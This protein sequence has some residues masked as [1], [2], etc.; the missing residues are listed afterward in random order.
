MTVTQSEKELR[1]KAEELSKKYLIIDTHIDVPYRL[2]IDFEDVS[3]KTQRG[4]FDFV[5]AKTGGL[6]AVFMAI[7][8]PAEFEEKG[9]GK[10]F[11]EELIE[12]IRELTSKNPDKF[13]LAASAEEI[14]RN[15]VNDKI[16]VL[17]GMENGTG[18]ENCLDNIEYFYKKGIRYITL[19]HS[20]CNQ[21]CDSSYDDERK[22]NG[23]SLFGEKVI[24]EMNRLGMIVDISHV[25]DS[26][27]YDIIKHSKTPVAAT[28]SSCRH[29]TPDWERNMSDE[30]IKML[31]ENNGIMMISFGSIFI[32]GEFRKRSDQIHKELVQ[33]LKEKEIKY[34][35]TSARNLVDEYFKMN[36]LKNVK[37]EQV[38]DHIDHVKKLVGVD[39][40]GFGSDFDG[41][42]FMPRGLDDVSMYPNLIFELLKRGYS[43]DEIEKICSKNF[44]RVW[45]EIESIG[46][47]LRKEIQK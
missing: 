10:K 37:I 36:N 47:K 38:A 5:R 32:D 44:L 24:A 28:H 2:Q 6:D 46:K 7:Y 30:M 21:I 35:D 39:Y 19:A 20:K 41:V 23:L 4:H 42:R 43:E 18:I 22:W 27:F 3:Q 34:G 16:S 33:F 1:T 12:G 17:F 26:S 45:E 40:I 13:S 8:I 15:F 29:F 11:A 14:K 9:G 25:S 31:A